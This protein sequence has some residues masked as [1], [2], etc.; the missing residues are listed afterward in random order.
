[1]NPK[2]AV[3][4][5][6]TPM[7]AVPAPVLAELAVGMQEG[8]LKYGRHNFREAS[9][10]AS[11]YYD[12][13][14]RHL[15]QFWEGEDIDP[16]SGASHI[17]KAIACLVVFRDGMMNEQWIDDRPPRPAPGWMERANE[18]TKALAERYLDPPA[19]HVEQE[20]PQ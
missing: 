19:P 11:V 5:K 16:D 15:M 10:R 20:I 13:A 18:Q 7:S 9:L 2:D 4:S 12:A 8:A 17:S 14:M 3:G 1:M 6:K